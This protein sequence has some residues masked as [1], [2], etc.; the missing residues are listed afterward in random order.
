MRNRRVTVV[1]TVCVG[2]FMVSLDLFI[3]NV[4]FPDI[5]ESF[6]GTSVSDLS[7]ILNAYAIAFGA[8]LV[9]AGRWADRVG[10]KN[11]FLLGLGIFTVASAA[12][13]A[14]PSVLALVITR[15]LQAVGAA[16]V[17]PT[18]LGLLLPEWPL[19][20]RGT[21]VGIWS[22]VSGVAA[23]AGPPL[24]GLL[25]QAGWR[26]VFI[27]NVPIGIAF[28]AV[29]LRVLLNRRDEHARGRPDVI[30]AGLFTVGIGALILAI[31]QGQSWGWSSGRVICLFAAAAVLT[32]VLAVRCARHPVP[33]VEP[34]IVR[35]RAI[36]LANLASILFFMGFAALLLGLVLFQTEVWDV[37]VLT[38]GLQLA[39]AP[40]T[41]AIFAVPGA[42][43]GQRF[44]QRYVGAAGAA[45]TALSGLWLR[46]HLELEPHY[47]SDMLPAGLIGGAGVGLVLPTL[48]AAATGPLPPSRFATGTAVLGM[49][50]QVGSA[51]GVALFVAILGQPTAATVID[52]FRD[53]WTFLIACGLA[54]GVALLSI[55]PVRIGAPG[56]SGEK[57][58]AETAEARA[59]PLVAYSKNPLEPRINR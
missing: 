33:L 9:P 45:L 24:G 31:V 8:L 7:W 18:S 1:L 16:M 40:L 36:A 15:A 14:A 10:R 37:S 5:Q 39:P 41:S 34:V 28:F 20:K 38:A 44:G 22:A 17:F 43:L 52:D 56:S 51:L 19:E 55:G 48:A 59:S 58:A 23:A 2:V 6:H 57:A 50:R 3:V 11:V 21:A 49:T 4:A 47:A 25:V 42:V 12:C 26:W 54:C 27:V 46:T 30:G 35:T 32:A 53:V 29:G 13:A